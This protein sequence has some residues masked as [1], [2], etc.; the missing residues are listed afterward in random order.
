MHIHIAASCIP[1]PAPSHA[2]LG[3]YV[4]VCVRERQMQNDAVILRNVWKLALLLP[5]LLPVMS[6]PTLLLNYMN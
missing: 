1:V 5:V 2:D 3:K 4:Y 6:I